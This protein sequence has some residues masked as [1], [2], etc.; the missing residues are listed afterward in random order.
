[1]NR[2]NQFGLQPLVS[3]SGTLD[4]GF[5]DPSQIQTPP[6]TRDS[7]YHSKGH[8]SHSVSAST[9][10][11]LVSVSTPTS[12]D[13]MYGTCIIND[14]SQFG[15]GGMQ[16]PSDM[17]GYPNLGPATAPA[18]QQSNHFWDNDGSYRS[19]DVDMAEAY[20]GVAGKREHPFKSHPAKELRWNGHPEANRNS[21]QHTSGLFTGDTS[22]AEPTAHQY[23]T[24]SVTPTNVVNPS[25]LFG[26][27]EAP[28]VSAVK[29]ALAA[30]KSSEKRQPYEHQT[31]ESAREKELAIESRKKH[32]RTSTASSSASSSNSMKPPIQRRNTDSVVS[33]D[34]QPVTDSRTAGHSNHRTSRRPS[35]T[36]RSSR[37]FLGSIA[38]N[39][40]PR[41]RTEVVLTVDKSG[42]AR[43]E[44]KVVEDEPASDEN[45]EPQYQEVWADGGSDTEDENDVYITSQNNSF[46]FSQ[47]AEPRSKKRSIESSRA[48]ALT[49][50]QA[51]S[52]LSDRI[53]VNDFGAGAGSHANRESS[54][55]ERA[56][57]YS[58]SILI[59]P[60]KRQDVSRSFDADADQPDGGAQ[61]AL[62]RV[63]EDRIRRQGSSHVSL[64]SDVVLIYLP[65]PPSRNPRSGANRNKRRAV[66]QA[67]AFSFSSPGDRSSFT[68]ADGTN[69]A[70]LV[71]SSK[72]TS[73]ASDGASPTSEG[74]RCVCSSAEG[75][76]ELMIQCESCMKWLHV[77]CVGL[78]ARQLPPVYVCV[79][80]TG[81]TPV[82]RGGRVREPI[83]GGSA[84][85]TP[86]AG[87]SL[88]SR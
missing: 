16:L 33:S 2:P 20:Q 41:T 21:F 38:E 61:V 79:F 75:N 86:L 48:T 49:L 53:A 15:F 71:G 4:A 10:S 64:A 45:P 8:H 55:L 35:P 80:C 85:Y 77:R 56:R 65:E 7:S 1:M 72:Y 40:R 87:K 13:S 83:R 44:T 42:R 28:A 18:M 27:P 39:V 67:G 24:H 47:P 60:D 68:L 31:R 23:P 34:A 78:R 81:Q 43:T 74:T 62:K 88:Y 52:K 69:A 14:S 11:T 73:P 6:P 9:P 30:S 3:P 46:C 59:E 25:L 50:S 84:I 36:K 22:L 51:A 5:M 58:T 82:A 26:V 19:L 57:R 29:S 70:S 37:S 66:T 54:K 17:A 12:I 76:G 63:V 32:S